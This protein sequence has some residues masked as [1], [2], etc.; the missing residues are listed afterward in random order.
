MHCLHFTGQDS[1]ITADHWSCCGELLESNAECAFAFVDA[2]DADVLQCDETTFWSSSGLL[3]LWFLSSAR[4][5]IY[6][7][8]FLTLIHL[9][10]CFLA[11]ILLFFS[12][13]HT[14]SLSHTACYQAAPRTATRDSGASRHAPATIARAPT[15]SRAHCARICR[16]ASTM[17]AHASR[18]ITGRAVERAAFPLRAL[19]QPPQPSLPRQRQWQR[20][21]RPLRG[22]RPPLRLRAA[23]VV[24]RANFACSRDAP[25]SA[26]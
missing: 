17:T 1:M 4:S 12:L 8:E 20:H 21:Q 18:V 3:N 13:F 15:M 11:F 14:L 26:L 9:V 10:T 23:V 16:T 2:F 6:T 5:F 7:F 24:T 22:Q 19:I 25:S